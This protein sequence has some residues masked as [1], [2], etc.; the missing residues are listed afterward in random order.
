MTISLQTLAAPVAGLEPATGRLGSLAGQGLRR[1]LDTI[2]LLDG[3]T[4]SALAAT[5]SLG[6]RGVRVVVADET[7]ATLAG[8]SKY[9]SE[10][11]TYP[12]PGADSD[13]FIAAISQECARRGVG[14]VFPMAEVSTGIVLRRRRELGGAA[15]PFVEAGTFD[16]I[17][18]KSQLVD[19]AQR[20]SIRA[21]KTHFVGDRESLQALYPRLEFPVVMKPCRSRIHSEGRWIAASVKYA[22][23]VRELEEH[24]DRFEFFRMHPFLVQEYIRG[25][26]HGIF[27]L[28]DR[29]RPVAWFAHRRLRER[30]PSGGVSVL[31]E[32]LDCDPVA[33]RM[34]RTLLDYIGWHG[35]AMVE[36]KVTREGV[37]Y[38]M[39]VNGRF[40]GSLQLAIDAG[41][42][43]PWL[44]YQLATGRTLDQA[45]D[46]V[47][48]VRSRWLLGDLASLYR[49]LSGNAS[50]FHS[51]PAHRAASVMRFL[52]LIDRRT[53]YDVN[54]W[55]DI[56]P[57][58]FELS[59]CFGH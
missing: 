28:Y 25:R 52:N 32:S 57:F 15:V 38:L 7:K 56:K 41:V 13:A 26:G 54:R 40:W 58:F 39:E 44:L 49:T 55:D 9:C 22:G 43:F 50:A 1:D 45:H 3:N 37:P 8:S 35:V 17:S 31:S 51:L 24:V 23:S 27:A 2:L 48:G 6:R 36:F 29:G 33:Q 16:R 21:P 10:T 20:L 47:R 18:D 59:H 12:P 30:P 53:R 19:L 42:D 5:R 11:F 4:R 34:A 14:V 46:Y